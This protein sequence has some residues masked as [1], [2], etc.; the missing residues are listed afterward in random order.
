MTFFVRF[1]ETFITMR[2]TITYT[3]LRQVLLTLGFKPV[4]SSGPQRVF[5]NPSYDALVVLP[6]PNGDLA[7]NA[8][9][10]AVVRRTVVEKG[11]TDDESFSRLL[12]KAANAGPSNPS[13][14]RVKRT[15]LRAH[16][17]RGKVKGGKER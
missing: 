2:N 6:P 4:R 16:P 13:L 5:R 12:T 17:R 10:L 15:A 14:V 3:K 8:L 1:K 7:L 9:H 11:V